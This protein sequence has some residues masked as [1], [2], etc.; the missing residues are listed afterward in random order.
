VN[1]NTLQQEPG[2]TLTLNEVG[3]C[4]LALG[5][6]IAGDPYRE[7]RATGS[8][9]LIDRLTNAT[10]GAGMIVAVLQRAEHATEVELDRQTRA[11]QKGQRP[12]V[13]WLTGHRG[14][15]KSAVARQ[16]EKK[17]Y[18]LGRHTYVLDEKN[19]GVGDPGLQAAA[20]ARVLTDAGLIVLVAIEAPLRSQRRTAREL[21]A[22]EEFVEIFIDAP[23]S[24]GEPPEPGFEPPEGAEIVI[25]SAVA[26]GDLAERIVVELYG[27]VLAPDK[28]LGAGI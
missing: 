20:M 8:F 10:V 16:V 25:G 6:A 2:N 19:V 28:L 23:L 14:V 5:K 7:N 21:F 24:D 1:V 4:N 26:T 17:L 3:V 22:S 27:G 15:E 12:R 9:I 18:C 11:L 13:L